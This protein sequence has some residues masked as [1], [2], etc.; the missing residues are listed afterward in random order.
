MSEEIRLFGE[1]MYQRSTGI[2]QRRQIYELLL[3][4]ET[5]IFGIGT[6]LGKESSRTGICL[7]SDHQSFFQVLCK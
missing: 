7:K 6:C 4:I 2:G 3:V 5:Q 1:F